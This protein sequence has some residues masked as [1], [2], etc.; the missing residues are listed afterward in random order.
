MRVI[1]KSVNLVEKLLM[2]QCFL[3]F[4]LFFVPFHFL[5]PFRRVNFLENSP[6]GESPLI[7]QVGS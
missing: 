3:G 1:Y 7:S 2:V 5:R 4:S 6:A